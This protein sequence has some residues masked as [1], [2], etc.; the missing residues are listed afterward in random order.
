LFFFFFFF[1]FFFYEKKNI[2]VFIVQ[3]VSEALPLHL[4]IFVCS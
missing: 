3:Q 4:F 1:F 2:Y